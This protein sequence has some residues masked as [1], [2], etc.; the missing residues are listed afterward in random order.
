MPVRLRTAVF[1]LRL[2]LLLVLLRSLVLRLI[3]FLAALDRFVS[4]P[5]LP[6]N[7]LP[8]RLLLLPLPPLQLPVGLP[9]LRSELPLL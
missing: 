4:T 9:V 1:L 3:P 8:L 7:L 2:S 6:L 5:L